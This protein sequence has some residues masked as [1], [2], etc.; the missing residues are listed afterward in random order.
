MRLART[1]TFYIGDAAGVLRAYRVGD[2]PISF[3]SAGSAAVPSEVPTVPPITLGI[4][5]STHAP[6]LAPT[7]NP[8]LFPTATPP[9]TPRAES[10]SEE[11]PTVDSVSGAG[12]NGRGVSF[13]VLAAGMLFAL[14][15]Q[16]HTVAPPYAVVANAK[17]NA[18]FSRVVNYE[19]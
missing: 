9:T 18:V 17:D 15:F 12:S 7:L 1:V 14:A 16:R 10:G 6:S 3:P 4:N 5:A 2:F 8:S 13:V 11:P 19:I